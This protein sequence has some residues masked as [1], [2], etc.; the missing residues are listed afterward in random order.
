MGHVKKSVLVAHESHGEVNP[1]EKEG[2]GSPKRR[3]TEEEE[4]DGD[5]EAGAGDLI[6]D[7]PDDILRD[8]I[9]RLPTREACSTQVLAKRWRHLWRSTPL[10]LDYRSLLPLRR[11]NK[12]NALAVAV[13]GVISAVLS[14]HPGPCRCLCVPADSSRDTVDTWLRSAAVDN[15]QELEFLSNRGGAPPPP[16]PPPPVSLFRFSYTLHIATISRCELQYT[17]VHDLRFPRLKHL[18]LEDVTITEASLHAMIARC[19]LLECLLLARSVGFR[20][21]RINSP[22]LRS[23]GVLVASRR[24]AALP[25]QM[26]LEEIIVEDAP[27]LEKLLD[28]ALRNNLQLSVISAPKLETIGC[29]T[30]RWFGPR[31]M[32]G[33]TTVV[34][35]VSVVRLTEAVRT[36]RILAINMF[37]LNLAKVIDLM[38]CFP[39]LEKLYLKCCLS[40]GNNYWRCEYQT[41]IKILDI[42][43]KTVELENYR[44]TKPQID[45][46]QFFV[47]NAKV[48]ESMKFVVKSED[49][50]DGFVA[51]QHK[52]LQLDK[53]A[54]RC[55]H[56]K[57]TTDRCH[58]HADPECPIDIEHVQDL[59]FTDPFE[60]RC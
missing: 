30:D 11:H 4:D 42:R 3:R 28:L 14:A 29:L 37:V 40:A 20:R 48:L 55:A 34:K 35:G 21:V 31:I 24:I 12:G 53:R 38:R 25:R 57:F 43:L 19:P 18:G 23:L 2:G 36:V 49:Y 33:T 54:S 58:H 51:K 1:P 50:Y 52:M 60:C 45:F 59:S 27:L 47:L 56:F 15:L 7:L 6:G 39:C 26:Q 10:R 46:A 44:G 5:E 22:S 8:I 17:T 13:A 32:F 16:P 41:L 9:A